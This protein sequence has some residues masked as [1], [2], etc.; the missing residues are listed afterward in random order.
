MTVKFPFVKMQAVGNDF[1]VL[2]AEKW[3]LDTDWSGQS[4]KLCD[5]KFGIG[6]DGLL[7]LDRSMFAD[8]RMRMFNPDGSEDMC[9]NGLRCIALLAQ[10]RGLL[11]AGDSGTVET[12]D[13]MR[14]VSVDTW[15][16]PASIVAEM[17]V[18]LFA[19]RDLPATVPSS[20]ESLL[21]Y[22][23]EI[24]GFGTKTVSTVNTGSTH[25]I[26][27]VDELPEDDVFFT[28]SPLIELHPVFPERTSVLWTKVLNDGNSGRD[29]HLQVRIWE[30][31]AGETLG[32]GTG[33]CAAAILAIVQE[34]VSG[35]SVA[36]RSKGGMLHILSRGVNAP[37]QMTGP[38]EIVYA[39]AVSC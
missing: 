33:A 19:P 4:L 2:E 11:K 34:K 6:G 22:P 7:V 37:L 35:S 26:V 31:G 10:A 27:W 13:G 39:G 18:P 32:C 16:R 17:A 38:A 21:D 30:R 3:P 24:D 23:L 20:R 15:S 12:L 25:T 36:V 9:G 8:V 1:V 28:A 29:A 14:A 5:R